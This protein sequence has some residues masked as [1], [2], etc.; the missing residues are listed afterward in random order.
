M[1]ARPSPA[2]PPPMGARYARRAGRGSL[3]G[4]RCPERP[5]EHRPGPPRP[6]AMALRF[7]ANL[8][9]LFPEL[10]ALPARLEAAAAA[11]FGAVEA[12]W[13]AGCPAQEL[14]AAAER[15][16]VRIALLNTPPGTAASRC[17]PWAWGSEDPPPTLPLSPRGPGGGRAGAGGRA[18]AAGSLPAGPGGGRALRQGCGLPQ[19]GARR[20]PR[21]GRGP[22]AAGGVPLLLGCSS[23]APEQSLPFAPGCLP[24]PGHGASPGSISCSAVSGRSQLGADPA[25]RGRGLSV[26]GPRAARHEPDPALR[27]RGSCSHLHTTAP[28]I[29]LPFSSST[30][31]IVSTRTSQ[32]LLC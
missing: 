21:S 17:S 26:L 8:S 9:W 29:I 18:R 24:P 15:A 31:R 27:S 23:A 28:R 32:Q 3:G 1:P 11:G 5:R 6:A 14:R 4:T 12:A 30:A 22:A 13:P 7:S 19:V 10:P 20:D 2:L 25:V 16:R